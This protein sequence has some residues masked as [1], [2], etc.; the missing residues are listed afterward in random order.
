LG[1]SIQELSFYFENIK[2]SLGNIDFFAFV[3]FIYK[4]PQILN[5]LR[6]INLNMNMS[7]WGTSYKVSGGGSYGSTPVSSVPGSGGSSSSSSSRALGDAFLTAFSP[8][9]LAQ[10]KD[11]QKID[12]KNGVINS[13]DSLKQFDKK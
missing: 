9:E 4:R 12:L 7:N 2:A 3:F 11:G 13:I 6:M 10:L 5:N 1:V 8:Q